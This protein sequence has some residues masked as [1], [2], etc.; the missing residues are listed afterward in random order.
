VGGGEGEEVVVTLHHQ[1]HRTQW[2][3][4]RQGKGTPGSLKQKKKIF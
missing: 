3:D 4:Q 2:R 1:H